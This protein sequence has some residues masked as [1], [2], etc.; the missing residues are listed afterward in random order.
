MPAWSDKS[1]TSPQGARHL[2]ETLDNEIQR[3][4][5]GWGGRGEDGEGSGR[6]FLVGF[7]PWAP[8]GQSAGCGVAI[9]KAAS[10]EGERHSCRKERKGVPCLGNSA[11][12]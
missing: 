2:E 1:C 12:S 7:S 5:R 6:L 9:P 3:E 11:R 10:T 4:D 8:E